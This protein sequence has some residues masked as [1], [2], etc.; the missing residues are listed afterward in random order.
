MQPLE[1]YWHLLL[2]ALSHVLGRRGLLPC[3]RLKC[4]CSC[5]HWRCRRE[6]RL[7]ALS[8]VLWL[9]RRCLVGVGEFWFIRCYWLRLRCL[10]GAAGWR[11]VVADQ[12]SKDG[13]DVRQPLSEV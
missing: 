8:Q 9:C 12:Y 4:I 7:L 13:V 10:V 6:L 5:C 1:V 2:L 3:I 11:I